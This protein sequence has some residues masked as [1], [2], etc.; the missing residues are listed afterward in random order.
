MISLAQY[1]VA[2][3]RGWAVDSTNPRLRVRGELDQADQE[4]ALLW[5]QMRIQNV[6]VEL[7]PP[8]RRPF[9]PPTERMAILEVKAARGWS[10]E[11][12]AKAFLV[13]AATIASWMGR[14]DEEGPDALVQLPEPDYTSVR[15]PSQEM[16]PAKG[17]QTATLRGHRQT[18]RDCGMVQ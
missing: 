2:Y 18:W 11:Q 9:Y 14:V 16:V 17:N 1:T 13:T 6:R 12:T 10:F 7:I 15:R 8:H 4:I 3:T 5:E